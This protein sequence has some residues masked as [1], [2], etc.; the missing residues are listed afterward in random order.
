MTKIAPPMA[1]MTKM[2]DNPAPG[3]PADLGKLHIM[4]VSELKGTIDT[5]LVLISA[6]LDGVRKTIDGYGQRIMNGEQRL[7]GY[8]DRI[9]ALEERYTLLENKKKFLTDTI[10][11]SRCS[12]IYSS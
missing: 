3:L 5:V 9:V 11:K 10:D 1:E 6:T 8:N 4:M 7:S 12:N 2:S